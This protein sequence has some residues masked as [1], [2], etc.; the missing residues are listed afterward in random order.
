MTALASESGVKCFFLQVQMLVLQNTGPER[1]PVT[2]RPA[3]TVD[4]VF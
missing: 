1:L 3:V 2:V 4:S